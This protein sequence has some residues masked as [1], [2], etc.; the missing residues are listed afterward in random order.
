MPLHP[1]PATAARDSVSAMAACL[2]ARHACRPGPRALRR[3]HLGRPNHHQADAFPRKCPRAAWRATSVQRPAWC[4]DT[5]ARSGLP[6]WVEPPERRLAMAGAA[7][8]AVQAKARCRSSIPER[9]TNLRLLVL[10]R[11]IPD[12]RMG[13]VALP[14]RKQPACQACWR[15]IAE[16]LWSGRASRLRR[17]VAIS[18]RVGKMTVSGPG[19]PKT[20]ERDFSAAERPIQNLICISQRRPASTYRGVLLERAIQ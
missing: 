2:R 10:L 14:W 15:A 5:A 20:G 17:R 8:P 7:Q 3:R 4:P 6:S 12:A 9:I 16:R 1:T 13:S 11:V 18:S 19:P